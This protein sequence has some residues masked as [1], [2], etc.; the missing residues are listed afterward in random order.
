MLLYGDWNMYVLNL[1]LFGFVLFCFV[2]V[3]VFWKNNAFLVRGSFVVSFSTFL[4]AVVVVVVVVVYRV[5]ESEW[6]RDNNDGDRDVIP[7][8]QNYTRVES[9]SRSMHGS[10]SWKAKWQPPKNF[11]SWSFDS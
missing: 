7:R 6:E 2:F 10:Y 4:V 5:L 11:N 3:F 8:V 1:Q 9:R